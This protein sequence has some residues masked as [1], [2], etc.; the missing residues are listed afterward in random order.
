MTFE[1]IRKQLEERGQTQL[2]RFYEEL[3]EEEQ[4]TLLEEISRIDFDMIDHPQG[5]DGGGVITPIG[6]LT[7]DQIHDQDNT[8]I[9]TQMCT[10]FIER[11]SVRDLRDRNR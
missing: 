8:H 3:N 9:K 11:E 5:T 1:Q 10:T 2:L 6:A 4:K 7:L